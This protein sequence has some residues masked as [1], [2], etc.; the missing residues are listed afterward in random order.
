MQLGLPAGG[1]DAIKTQNSYN[2]DQAFTDMI[3]MWLRQLYDVDRHGRPTRKRL[4]AA[5]SS[6][7]GGKN[8]ALARR[9]AAK[10]PG[11]HA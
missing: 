9:A 8:P 11:M 6:P 3:L 4:L 1:L 5:V 2:L 10:I 7:S